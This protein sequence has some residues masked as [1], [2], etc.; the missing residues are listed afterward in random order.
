M[1]SPYWANRQLPIPHWTIIFTELI[2]CN[3]IT[4]DK[5]EIKHVSLCLYNMEGTTLVMLAKQL[6]TVG[7]LG[8]TKC[9]GESDLLNGRVRTEHKACAIVTPFISDKNTCLSVNIDFD[10]VSTKGRRL[11]HK[12][13]RSHEQA[14][15]HN[16]TTVSY[17]FL[18]CFAFSLLT[19]YIVW[20][21][22][23]Q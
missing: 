5:L 10:W 18:L 16:A 9:L 21:R 15:L 12:Y 20:V 3:T 1:S 13:H 4:S 6:W 7:L 19:A 2:I 23:T 14:D 22:T 17:N 11:L 8:Q